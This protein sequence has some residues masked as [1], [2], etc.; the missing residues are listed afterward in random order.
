MLKVNENRMQDTTNRAE[1][2]PKERLN[3]RVYNSEDLRYARN[4][5]YQDYGNW[6]VETDTLGEAQDFVQEAQDKDPDCDYIILYTEEL[7][8]QFTIQREI[9]KSL[10]DQKVKSLLEFIE[11]RQYVGIPKS[12]LDALILINETNEVLEKI[13]WY[14]DDLYKEQSKNAE[15]EWNH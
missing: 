14:M 7:M 12:T 2:F 6:I 15:A 5:Q 4:G 13:S 8:Y 9:D 10:L 11:K 3:C 1:L